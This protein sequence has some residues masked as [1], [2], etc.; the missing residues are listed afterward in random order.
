MPN[1][2]PGGNILNRHATPNVGRDG[3]GLVTT[4]EIIP[5][6]RT[7]LGENLEDVPISLL[8]NAENPVDKLPWH[9][10]V[11]KVAHGIHEN[12][13]WST[14]PEGM[15]QPV[16]AELKVEPSLVRVAN[17]TP[18]PLGEPFGI[19]VI[20]AP[21]NLGTPCYWVPSRISP[22]NCRVVG[23]NSAKERQGNS[24]H[25]NR[26][27]LLS[28]SP[29]GNQQEHNTT[30]EPSSSRGNCHIRDKL[31]PNPISS[32]PQGGCHSGIFAG[33]MGQD[34]RLVE[35]VGGIGELD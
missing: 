12:S 2:D 6:Q 18:K 23:H 5:H 10:F 33:H 3:R 32:P 27:T 25:P 24:R 17:N 1:P 28:W 13:A 31:L 29:V 15:P 16:A 11:K 35:K 9:V 30:N 8:H 21:R 20:A 26:C 19:T 4:A 14:P 34:P 22:F 7:S